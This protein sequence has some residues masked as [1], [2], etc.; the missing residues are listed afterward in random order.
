[1]PEQESDETTQMLPLARAADPHTAPIP[2]FV[3]ATGRRR[4]AAQRIAVG[5]FLAAGGYSLMVLWS[6][7]GGPVSPDTLMPFSAPHAAPAVQSAQPSAAGTAGVVPAPSAARSGAVTVTVPTRSASPSASSATSASASASAS[8][9]PSAAATGH[10]P[11]S[12]GKPSKTS[13]PGHGG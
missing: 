11:T 9:N 7:L 8:A 2:V 6:F 5:A 13:T 12:P 4:R 3:D 1:M 10:R